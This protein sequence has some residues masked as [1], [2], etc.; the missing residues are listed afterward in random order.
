MAADRISSV[1]ACLSKVLYLPVNLQVIGPCGTSTSSTLYSC[2]YFLIPLFL[3][4]YRSRYSSVSTVIRLR[5]GRRGIG[6]RIPAE[7]ETVMCS[8]AFTPSLERSQPPNGHASPRF[9][10]KA[11]SSEG[12]LFSSCI[13]C[14][15]CISY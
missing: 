4:I 13:I 7:E 8:A 2:Y 11:C 15:F 14:L 10:G 12:H 1:I 3:Y 9:H 6:A 5:A